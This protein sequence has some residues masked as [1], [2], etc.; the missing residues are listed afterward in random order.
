M[1]ST[2][3]PVRDEKIICTVDTV[4]FCQLPPDAY[5]R[6]KQSGLNIPEG[7]PHR[8]RNMCTEASGGD[9]P[10]STAKLEKL[11]TSTAAKKGAH[12]RKSIQSGIGRLI[13]GTERRYALGCM[14]FLVVHVTYDSILRYCFYHFAGTLRIQHKG[15]KS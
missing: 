12:L 10:S 4:E 9:N 14:H 13:H 7:T 2:E 6:L 1:P 15:L 8:S 5:D 11:M 3:D